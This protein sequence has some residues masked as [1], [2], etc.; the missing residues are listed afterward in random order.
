VQFRFE[1]YNSF[2]HSQFSG[3]DT[4]ARFNAAGAQTN[5]RFGQYTSARDARKVQLGLKFAF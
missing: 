4:A 1:T 3:V 5:Q 2:N